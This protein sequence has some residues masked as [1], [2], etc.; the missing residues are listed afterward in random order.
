[1]MDNPIPRRWMIRGIVGCSLLIAILGYSYWNLSSWS[2]EYKTDQG[3]S[4]VYSVPLKTQITCSLGF[5]MAVTAVIL[6]LI[7]LA[8]GRLFA[9][10]QW[11]LDPLTQAFKVRPPEDLNGAT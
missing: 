5:G 10:L 9:F 3:V 8:A 7:L 4:M 2:C 11:H 6:M 1:M